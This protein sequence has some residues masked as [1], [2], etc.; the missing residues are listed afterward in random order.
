MFKHKHS[1]FEE[2]TE[3]SL[4]LFPKH[5]WISHLSPDIPGLHSTC[6]KF[7][8]DSIAQNF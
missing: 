2:Q 4:K 5:E 8:I 3:E 7:L 1:P 6:V